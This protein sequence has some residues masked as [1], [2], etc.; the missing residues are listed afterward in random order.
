[1]PIRLFSPKGTV[2]ALIAFFE[3]IIILPIALAIDIIGIILICFGLDDFG[4]LDTIAFVVFFP[5]TLMRML[6]FGIDDYFEEE[7]KEAAQESQPQRK[8]APPKM[9]PVSQIKQ[10]RRARK[11]AKKAL[12]KV[13]KKTAKKGTKSGIRFLVS[14]FGELIPYLGALP[15]WTVTVVWELWGS[16][17]RLFSPD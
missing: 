17:K 4:I 11:G 12:K 8:E 16:I 9:R 2:E 6:Y 7:I 10:G 15:F 3:I 14:L 5:W 1:M 13:A